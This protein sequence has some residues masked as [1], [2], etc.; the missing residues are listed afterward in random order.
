MNEHSAHSDPRVRFAAERTLLAWIRTGVALMGL[1]FVVARFGWFLREIAG[2]EHQPAT[3]IVS[4]WI[5][6]GLIGLGIIVNLFAAREHLRVIRQ[7]ARGEQ[8]RPPQWSLG[9]VVA[10]VVAILGCGMGLYLVLM[11]SR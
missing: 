3:G 6:V 1:G 4:L 10:G 8:Y 7:L 9:I 11:S 2:R 5:G